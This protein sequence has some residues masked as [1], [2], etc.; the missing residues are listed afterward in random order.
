M[1]ESTPDLKIEFYGACGPLGR[2]PGDKNVRKE[3]FHLGS[4][5][6]IRYVYRT[7]KRP[8]V[9]YDVFSPTRR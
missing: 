1:I 2:Y 8:I 7:I 3:V 5:W 9:T 4:G 6:L